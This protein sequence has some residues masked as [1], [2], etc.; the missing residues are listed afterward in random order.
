MKKLLSVLLLTFSFSSMAASVVTKVPAFAG[1]IVAVEGLD[2]TSLKIEIENH[3]C[4]IGTCAGG[5]TDMKKINVEIVSENNGTSLKFKSPKALTH[6]SKRLFG[7]FSSCSI[8]LTAEGRSENGTP[9]DGVLRLAYST[10]AKECGSEAVMG[11]KL[12]KDLASPIKA[13]V[14]A[15]NVNTLRMVKGL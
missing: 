8:K 4:S 2:I 1:S 10:D 3:F 5:P 6:S 15:G 9:V 12:A 11:Q 7:N 13:T 14:Q